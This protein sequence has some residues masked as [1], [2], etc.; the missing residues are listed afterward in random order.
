ARRTAAVWTLGIAMALVLVAAHLAL[1][2][3][4]PYLSSRPLAERIA[5]QLR[6]EDRVMI[7]GDQAFGSSLLFYLQRPIELV[8]G[9][10]TSMEFGSHY[11]DAPRI[12]L[13]D[14]DLLR[15]WSAPQRV[16]LFV[17]RERRREVEALLPAPRFVVAESSGKAIFSNRR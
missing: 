9:R 14:A 10:S 7:Y 8:N 16:L 5:P 17:P 6:A 1:V 3:F 12:F 11:P 15:A 4:E 13:N 2:R